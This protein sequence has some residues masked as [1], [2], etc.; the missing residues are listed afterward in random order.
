MGKIRKEALFPDF[1]AFIP[2]DGTVETVQDYTYYPDHHPIRL[3]ADFPHQRGFLKLERVH[4]NGELHTPPPLNLCA[5]NRIRIQCHA[6][7]PSGHTDNQIRWS[8]HEIRRVTPGIPGTGSGFVELVE[9]CNFDPTPGTNV[10]RIKSL[11]QHYIDGRLYDE[12]EK[13]NVRLVNGFYY[14]ERDLMRMKD[15]HLNL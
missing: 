7:L 4:H 1:T 13:K 12:V 2:Q 8:Y 3:A 5:G 11:A 9:P 6:Y 14:K 10:K 15:L